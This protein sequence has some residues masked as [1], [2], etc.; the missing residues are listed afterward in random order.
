MRYMDLRRALAARGDANAY[1]RSDDAVYRM[2]Y[3]RPMPATDPL[4]EPVEDPAEDYSAEERAL[5]KRMTAIEREAYL[6][7]RDAAEVGDLAPSYRELQEALNGGT[8]WHV[9]KTLTSLERMG[10]IRCI[11]KRP[12]MAFWLPAAGIQTDTTGLRVSNDYA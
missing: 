12:R 3:G 1:V 4:P 7:I 5:L 10:A 9:Q 2:I 8:P 11:A 6:E